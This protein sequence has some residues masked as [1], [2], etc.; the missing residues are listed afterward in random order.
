MFSE[1]GNV[2]S[3]KVAS[4]IFT[5]TCRG[6]AFIEMEGHQARSAIAALD[7]KI[8]GDNERRLCVR[9]ENTHKLHGRRRR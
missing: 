9:Y 6:F 3:L 1:F 5:G 4:D 7:G 2:R 8:I